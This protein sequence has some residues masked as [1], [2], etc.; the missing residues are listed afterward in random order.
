MTASVSILSLWFIQ[1]TELVGEGESCCGSSSNLLNQICWHALSWCLKQLP[2]RL[3]FYS[4]V[5]WSQ[6]FL[7]FSQPSV[8][9]EALRKC[10]AIILYGLDGHFSTSWV[11]VSEVLCGHVCAI[12]YHFSWKCS[13]YQGSGSLSVHFSIVCVV[14]NQAHSFTCP[15]FSSCFLV[16]TLPPTPIFLP[17]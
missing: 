16:T 4:A 6:L 14:A 11:S 15:E 8:W 10:P 17:S 3:S 12:V 9:T 5:S 2:C 1:Q 7:G 13:F